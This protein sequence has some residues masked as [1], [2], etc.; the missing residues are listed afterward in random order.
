MNAADLET[1]SVTSRDIVVRDRV[2]ND[3]SVTQGFTSAELQTPLSHVDVLSTPSTC[4]TSPS[5]A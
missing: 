1:R 2:P 4:R 5:V 3:I